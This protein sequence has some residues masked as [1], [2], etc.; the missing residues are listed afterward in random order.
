[1]S[2]N[3]AAGDRRCHQRG[4][5]PVQRW[6]A[7]TRDCL[8]TGREPELSGRKALRTTELLFATYESSRCRGRVTLPLEI[9]DSPLLTRVEQGF[10]QPVEA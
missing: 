1:V 7:C 2:H 5:H 4:G 9:D 3:S 8:E 10:W 6:P